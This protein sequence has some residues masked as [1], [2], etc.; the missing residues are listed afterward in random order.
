VGYLYGAAA[1]I[2]LVF[3]QLCAEELVCR[4][5]FGKQLEG[6]AEMRK[7]KDCSV[8]SNICCVNSVAAEG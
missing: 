4:L 1:S 5:E 8:S 6:S 3:R 2:V 7:Q